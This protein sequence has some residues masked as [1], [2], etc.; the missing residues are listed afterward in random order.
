MQEKTFVSFLLSTS[1]EAMSA[2]LLP[3]DRRVAVI[4][5]AATRGFGKTVLLVPLRVA[6][7][8]MR[9]QSRC[10]E[11]RKSKAEQPMGL[12]RHSQAPTT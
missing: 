12:L 3:E 4:D 5:A 2:L 9:R 1:N 8:R 10:A 6:N 11:G 7:L